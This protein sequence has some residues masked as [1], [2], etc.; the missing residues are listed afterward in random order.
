MLKRRILAKWLAVIL[1]LIVAVGCCLALNATREKAEKTKH[2]ETAEIL[3][4]IP[5]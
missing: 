3:L 2:V 1:L 4:I 5:Y